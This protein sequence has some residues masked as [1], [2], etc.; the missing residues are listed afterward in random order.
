MV[1]QYTAI[2]I[3]I[4]CIAGSLLF[5]KVR[6]PLRILAVV[7]LLGAMASS[8][9]VIQSA[10]T[11]A[12]EQAGYAK[13]APVSEDFINGAE[14][15]TRI[16]SEAIWPI[17]IASMCLAILAFLPMGGRGEFGGFNSEAQHRE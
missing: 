17:A 9:V 10:D 5:P 11:F 1:F 14:H 16:A 7:F 6:I 15:A 8:G 13:D 3:G 4:L 12:R 2:T